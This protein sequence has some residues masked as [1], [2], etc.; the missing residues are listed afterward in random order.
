[1]LR[2]ILF[3]AVSGEKLLFLL[4]WWRVSQRDAPRRAA[5]MRACTESAKYDGVA[6]VVCMR[7]RAH[8]HGH[9]PVC[10]F[11]VVHGGTAK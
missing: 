3:E 1:M 2:R 10:T 11:T 6:R 4:P 8:G 5:P 7:A 9:A